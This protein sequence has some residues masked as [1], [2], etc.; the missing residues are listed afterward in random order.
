MRNYF[1]F[2]KAKY[3]VTEHDILQCEENKITTWHF[4]LKEEV[5]DHSY[6]STILFLT[7]SHIQSC[8]FSQNPSSHST[9]MK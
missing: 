7:T 5:K 8:E 4:K 3:S 2:K 9:F 1:E 6:Q